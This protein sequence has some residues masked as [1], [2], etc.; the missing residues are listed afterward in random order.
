MNCT[1]TAFIDL[2]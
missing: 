1:S 2:S